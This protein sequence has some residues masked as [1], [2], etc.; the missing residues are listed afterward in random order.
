MNIDEKIILIKK[1]LIIIV[2][3]TKGNFLSELFVFFLNKDSQSSEK[4][5]TY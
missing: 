4:L 2:I 1:T 5:N 3:M